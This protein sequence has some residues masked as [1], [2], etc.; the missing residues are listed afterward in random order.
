MT[1]GKLNLAKLNFL[2]AKLNFLLHR[3]SMISS[4]ASCDSSIM[5]KAGISVRQ[6]WSESSKVLR[7]LF[8][9]VLSEKPRIYI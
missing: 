1:I 5:G 4:I 2:L 3:Y 7:D 9:K 8:E 6:V